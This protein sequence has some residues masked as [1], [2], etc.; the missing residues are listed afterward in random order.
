MYP[1]WFKNN[2]IK[3]LK[4]PTATTFFPSKII[5]QLFNFYQT[6]PSR[7]FSIDMPFGIGLKIRT[8]V[9][10]ML[11]IV[12]QSADTTASATTQTPNLIESQPPVAYE[13]HLDIPAP[14]PSPTPT[15]KNY[16]M[17][18]PCNQ[19]DYCVEQLQSLGIPAR[20][21]AYEPYPN[22]KKA[23]EI[24]NPDLAMFKCEYG[25][26]LFPKEASQLWQMGW[27]SEITAK[28]AVGKDKAHLITDPNACAAHYPWRPFYS[29]RSRKPSGTHDE[30]LAL[31]SKRLRKTY[32]RH[33]KIR[34]FSQGTYYNLSVEKEAGAGELDP[35]DEEME[36]EPKPVASGSK[37][38]RTEEEVVL[39]ESPPKR[40]KLTPASNLPST[41]YFTTTQTPVPST[42][43]LTKRVGR[44]LVRTETLFVGP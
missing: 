2:E 34:V 29:W 18:D 17:E 28:E 12:Y 3:R 15:E 41:S 31:L 27:I 19:Q 11:S 25:V 10:G 7:T 22:E 35:L 20:D 24:V 39:E 36:V 33:T 44:P 37:R 5:H 23:P 21:F 6:M 4:T 43:I 14:P 32:E 1:L 26:K 8:Q 40:A 30:I 13:M 16:Y 38:S 9:S 42:S